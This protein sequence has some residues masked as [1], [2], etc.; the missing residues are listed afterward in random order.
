MT[1]LASVPPAGVK[2]PLWKKELEEAEAR[3]A[4][5]EEAAEVS[6]EEDEQRPTAENPA[7]GGAEGETEAREPEERAA[8]ERS[9]VSYCPLR[10]EPSG[11]Q[12]APLRRVDSSF[13]SWLSPLVLL[14]GL[15]APA[16]R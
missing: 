9:S 15:A 6:G 3:E 5:R 14:A 12:V 13:W 11:Q 10:Q 1:A 16:E 7:E 4:E 8:G 2:T